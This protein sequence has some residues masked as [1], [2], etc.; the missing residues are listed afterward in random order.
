MDHV[1]RL[2]KGKQALQLCLR[3]HTNSDKYRF[4]SLQPMLSVLLVH[5]ARGLFVYFLFHHLEKIGHNSDGV[6]KLR[7]D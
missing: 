5:K 7:S 2:H 1:T 6:G 4:L 3:T